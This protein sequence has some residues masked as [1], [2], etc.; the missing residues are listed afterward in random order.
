[1]SSSFNV[2]KE[3]ENNIFQ[4]IY[5]FFPE[6]EV[7]VL[8]DLSALLVKDRVSGSHDRVGGRENVGY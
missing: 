3:R 7:I 6:A 5:F 2:V 8:R 4:N 1:M